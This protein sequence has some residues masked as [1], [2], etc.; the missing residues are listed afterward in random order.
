ME[1]IKVII[2]DDHQLL[3]AGLKKLLAEMPGVLVQAEVADGHAALLACAENQPDVVLMDVAMPGMG[4]LDALRE[5]RVRYP[6]LRVL[7][8]S[9]FDSAE[10]VL[11]A[12]RLGAAGYLLK[13][14][15][16]A[17]LEL[18]IKAVMRGET[19]LSSAVSRVV[20]DGYMA[21]QEAASPA[22]TILTPRQQEILCL[23]AE[24]QSTKAIANTLALS[25]K[26]VETHRTQIMEKIN[27]HD[28]AGLVRYAVRTGVIQA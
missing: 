12:L 28:L 8:L 20:I 10:H 26:T 17:E 1:T 25:V 7:M 3:R 15:A 13:D 23:I 24:G 11:Q 19:W 14:A 9:M 21:R 5:L 16:P 27:V 18:A 6:D 22:P 4:G 2:A